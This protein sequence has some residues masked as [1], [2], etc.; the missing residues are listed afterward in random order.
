MAYLGQTFYANDLPQG[1]PYEPLPAGWYTATIADAE[2]RATKDGSGQYIQVRYYITGP[3]H[4]G[5][6]V[7]GNI[8]IRNASAKAEE[9]GRQQL[10]ELMRAIG[11]ARVTDTDQLIGGVLQIKLGVR[12]ATEEYS[13]QNEVRG[14]KAITGAAPAFSPDDGKYANAAFIAAC[15]PDTIRALLGER[16]ALAATLAATEAARDGYRDDAR[17]LHAALVR[18][19]AQYESEF[20]HEDTHKF[21]P[22]WLREALARTNA[23]QEG[24]EGW[25]IEPE[26]LDAAKLASYERD[27]TLTKENHND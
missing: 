16:D 10:G 14:F 24:G 9:I 11:L 3:T 19:V 13:A 27:T 7:S 20:D 15:D 8:N 12:A 1:N 5:L 4:Q 23:L 26:T 22:Q 6:V 18:M 17:Q 21:R 25:E 2:L